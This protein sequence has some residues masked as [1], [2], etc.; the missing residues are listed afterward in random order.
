MHAI[1]LFAIHRPSALKRGRGIA[2]GCGPRAPSAHWRERVR[3]AGKLFSLAAN[4]WLVKGLTYGPFQPNSAGEFLPERAR[5][6]ADFARIRGMGANAF[7]VY[8]VPSPEVLD[9]ALRHD[10]RVM[11]DVPWEKHRCF[12]EDWSAQE[13]ARRRVRRAAREIGGHPAVFRD[14]RRERSPPRRGSVP[15]PGQ[16]APLPG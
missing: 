13:D 11:V 7:R 8:H 16:G 9:E 5:L 12:L 10:L 3:A 6:A 2:A 14:Q 1:G 15:R 4:P